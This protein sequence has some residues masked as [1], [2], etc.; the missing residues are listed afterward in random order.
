MEELFKPGFTTKSTGSGY[1]LFLAR[2]IAEEHG[3]TI[4]A[5]DRPGG[6][7]LFELILPVGGGE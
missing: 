2:R 4:H 6:G 1:G 5:S 7:A 3:G